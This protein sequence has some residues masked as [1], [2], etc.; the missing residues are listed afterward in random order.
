MRGFRSIVCLAILTVGTASLAQMPGDIVP[1]G[2]P[3]A[4][5]DL[6][7]EEGTRMVGGRWRYSD[8]KI[9]ETAFTAPG[10]D[11]TPTFARSCGYLRLLSRMP[12][13][14]AMTI[15]PGPRFRPNRQPAPLDR[16]TLLQLVPNYSHRAA[17]HR[18]FRSY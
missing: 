16:A 10:A 12:A 13:I 6:A 11:A 9:V 4:A 7:T 18:R 1:G 5:I 15:H 2:E 14:T 8:V 3:S 17:T